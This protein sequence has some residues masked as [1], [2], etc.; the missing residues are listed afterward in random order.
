MTYTQKRSLKLVLRV[1]ISAA[2]LIWLLFKTESKE[3]LDSLAEISPL[4]WA[5]AFLL[6]VCTQLIS[7]FRWYIIAHGLGFKGKWSTYLG[8]YFVGM[9]F[10]LFLPT[11]IGGDLLKVLFLSREDKKRL[12][13]TYSVLAD[14]VFGL[15]AM[16]LLGST[17]VIADPSALPHH[18]RTILLIVSVAVLAIPLCLL[19][20]N[21]VIKNQWR[22]IGKRVDI[23]LQLLKN[24]KVVGSAL[25]LSLILQFIGMGIIVIMAKDM[26]LTPAS[27]F[28]F[29]AYP[30]IALLTFLP[31]SLN[32][33]GIREGGFVFFMNLKGVPIEKALTLSF[34]FFAVQ[35][36]AALMGGGAYIFG[37]HKKSIPAAAITH[38]N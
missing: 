30:M 23:S 14:R 19:F 29:A 11:S 28:Y 27:S 34:S 4:T 26:E 24:K 13:A 15:A 25:L 10:N 38:G 31:I 37:A 9:Y 1:G 17:A 3:I 22:E 12:K 8:Y 35:V 5:T 36:A 2:L 7:S 20:V 16:F 6:Y 33:I 18:L 21:R 32:G